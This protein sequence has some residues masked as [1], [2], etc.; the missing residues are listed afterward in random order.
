MME[1]KETN[2]EEDNSH[3][4]ERFASYNPPVYDGALGPKASK[5]WIQGMEKLF[6][7]LRS[8]G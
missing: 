8:G 4:V 3:M 5:D 7:A 2:T 1:A 6:N